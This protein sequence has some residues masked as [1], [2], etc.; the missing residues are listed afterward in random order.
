MNIN[1]K[2]VR[3]PQKINP[4]PILEAVVEL[5]FD[6]PFPSDA[7]FGILYNQF[8]NDYPNVQELPILQLP[9][10]IRKQDPALKY[11]PC[12]KLS[13]SDGKF[14]F[15][16]GARVI[17]LINLNPYSGWELF[18]AKLK[19]LI[20]RV[21]K[22][23]ILSNYIRV[24]IRY[25]N[26]FDCNVLEKIS[27]SLNMDGQLL[28]DID[29]SVQLKV[30]A[31]PFVSTL[32]IVNNAQVKRIEGIVKGSIIDIDTYVENPQNDVIGVIEGGHLEEKKLFFKLLKKEFVEKELNPEY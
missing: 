11:K 32:R 27:L 8:K 29:A 24:G 7:I 28:T 21:K 16:I 31:S 13:S 18:S 9:E 3:L 26:G 23:E 6:S 2:D 1:L 22:L 14:L 5:R 17:S 30:P 25:R 4:C 20:Q 10:F 15:Q 12:Y 19:D